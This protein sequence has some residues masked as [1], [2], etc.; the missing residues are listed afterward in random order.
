ME[1]IDLK[2]KWK[3][4]YS[5]S[6][7]EISI[8]DVPEF[9]YL[10][11]DGKGDPNTSPEYSDAVEAL[12][13]LSYAAKF[14][15][16]KQTMIDYTVMPLEGLWWADSMDDFKTGRKDDWCWT[17]MVLQPEWVTDGVFRNA[18]DSV[19]KKKDLPALPKVRFTSFREGRCAQI[20]YRGAYSGEAPTIK[21][22]H[23]SINTNG[24]VLTGKHHEIYLNDPRRTAPEKLRTIIRQPFC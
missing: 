4:L 16:K 17:M 21:R 15:I 8:I 23:D 22:I 20:L 5:P 7:T 19:Q 13:S 12:F 6:S 9:R 3:E 18:V 11:V 10:M 1:K 2:K 24:F 14:S